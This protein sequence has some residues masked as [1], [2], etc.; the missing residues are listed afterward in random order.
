MCLH[1]N[2]D[3]TC[4]RSTGVKATGLPVQIDPVVECIGIGCEEEMRITMDWGAFEFTVGYPYFLFYHL[5]QNHSGL[6]SFLLG[7]QHRVSVLVKWNN[8]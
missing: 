8:G 3:P 7:K 2:I 1:I 4:T 5:Y 6:I